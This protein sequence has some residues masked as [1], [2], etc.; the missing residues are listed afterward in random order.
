[1][2]DKN[3]R[4]VDL[5]KSLSTEK[6]RNEFHIKNKNNSERNLFFKMNPKSDNINLKYDIKKNNKSK[7]IY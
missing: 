4:K 7:N 5:F 1:M 3:I 2:T 6:N